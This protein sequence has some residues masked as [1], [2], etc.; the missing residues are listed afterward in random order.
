MA[1]FRNKIEHNKPIL[2]SQT[3]AN[4]QKKKQLNCSDIPGHYYSN[5]ELLTEAQIRTKLNVPHSWCPVLKTSLPP[6]AESESRRSHDFIQENYEHY[7]RR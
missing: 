7:L 5:T 4:L 2:L 1:N 6:S 3:N